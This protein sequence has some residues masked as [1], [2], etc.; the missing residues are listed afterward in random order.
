MTLRSTTFDIYTGA[1][2]YN[3]ATAT[4]ISGTLP[5]SWTWA[6]DDIAEIRIED[7][8]YGTSYTTC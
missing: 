2:G 3:V 7:A 8:T 1:I 4:Q 6:Y 5:N